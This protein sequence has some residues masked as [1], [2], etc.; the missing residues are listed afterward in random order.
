VASIL[1]QYLVKNSPDQASIGIRS[2]SNF[3]DSL[4]IELARSNKKDAQ[5]SLYNFFGGMDEVIGAI[6]SRPSFWKTVI[7]DI[8]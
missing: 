8:C 5:N 7:E 2:I 3:S 6:R 1:C 4:K